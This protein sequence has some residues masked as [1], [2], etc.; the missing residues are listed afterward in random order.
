[1]TTASIVSTGD[2]EKYNSRKKTYFIDLDG[3]LLFK[4]EFL[5][6]QDWANKD[7][8]TCKGAVAWVNSLEKAG[9][10]IILVTARK[11]SHR[12]VTEELLLTL[13]FCWDLLIMGCTN[14]ERVIVNDGPCSVMRVETNV[15]WNS[16]SGW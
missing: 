1:M 10:K 15:N 9:H 7:I 13:G 12:K 4:N 16:V 14:G 11:E 2:D 6:R 8:M 5:T 3:T